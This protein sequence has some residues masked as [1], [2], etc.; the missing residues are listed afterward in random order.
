[1]V[2]PGSQRDDGKKFGMLC[3]GHPPGTGCCGVGMDAVTARVRYRHR[4]VD[5]LFRERIE[6]RGS[7]HQTLYLGPRTFQQC[8]VERE[9]MPKI[10]DKVCF[11][12]SANIIEHGPH[13]WIRF[14]TGNAFGC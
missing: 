1:M 8:R 2:G 12:H 11:P 14:G 6:V 13:A 7:R 3:I 5:H 9:G 10:V 4:D